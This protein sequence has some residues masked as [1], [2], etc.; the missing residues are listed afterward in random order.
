MLFAKVFLQNFS[1]IFWPQYIHTR[2]QIHTL[3]QKRKENIKQAVYEKKKLRE[4]G[5][6]PLNFRNSCQI[7]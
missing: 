1:I 5:N 6:F 2:A 4:N 3:E 7:M